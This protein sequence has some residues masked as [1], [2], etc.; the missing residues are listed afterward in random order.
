[1]GNLPTNFSPTYQDM[2]LKAVVSTT[3][4]ILSPTLT[5]M[6]TGTTYDLRTIDPVPFSR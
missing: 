6:F 1:M 3:T 5:V 4:L 2:L